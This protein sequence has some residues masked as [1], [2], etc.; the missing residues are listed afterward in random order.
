MKPGAT[1]L[2]KCRLCVLH[3]LYDSFESCRVVQSQIG[4]NFTVDLD[5]SFVDETHQLAVG[6]IF[7]AC[8]SVDALNPQS[9]EVALVVLAVAVGVGK[10]LLP[11]VLCYSPHVTTAAEVTAGKF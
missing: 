2:M 3:C 6:Q 5:T 9:A 7:H 1:I 11:G 10:T 4:Q 8:G